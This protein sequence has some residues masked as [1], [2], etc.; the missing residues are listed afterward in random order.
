ML[1][2]EFKTGRADPSISGNWSLY[3]RAARQLIRDAPA[4]FG[5]LI[6]L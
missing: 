5:T 2:V 3:V 6:Y 1:V 4:V